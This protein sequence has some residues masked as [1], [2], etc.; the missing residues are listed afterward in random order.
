MDFMIDLPM[1]K[2]IKYNAIMVVVNRLSKMAYFIPL[3]FGKGRAS[4]EFVVKLL[5]DHVFK[6]YGLPK[7]IMLDYNRRFTSDIH[8]NY[9]ALRES[10]N[11]C[12]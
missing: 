11:A 6:L 10:N 9:A 7:E 4:T 2:E 5:F 3:Y 8:V 1:T 12:P